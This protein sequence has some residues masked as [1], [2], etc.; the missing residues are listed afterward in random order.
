LACTNFTPG[1]GHQV[2]KKKKR[3]V[4]GLFGVGLDNEDGHNRITRSDNF[5]LLGGS[6][7]TH[8]QMQDIAI[9][10]DE[11]LKEKGKNLQETCVEEVIEILYKVSEK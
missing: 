3:E 4:V 9:R 7:E 11:T 8:E 5:V 6:Q 2:S 10:F 1:K